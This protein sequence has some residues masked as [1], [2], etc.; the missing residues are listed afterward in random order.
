MVFNK[1]VLFIHLG[2]TG[3]MSVTD[4]LCNTLEPPV[5]HVVQASEFNTSFTIFNEIII[6]WKRHANLVETANFLKERAI[7]LSDF[8]VVFIIV[9]NPLDLDLSYYKHLN[10]PLFV[11]SLAGN[12]ANQKL[13]EIASGEYEKFAKETFVHY[14]G[15]LCDFFEIKGKMPENLQILRFEDLAEAVPKLV[16]PFAVKEML[17]PHHNKSVEIKNQSDKL[18]DEA[19]ISIRDKYH[20]IWKNFYPNL[21][22]PLKS[23][24][25]KVTT[26]GKQYLFIG[27]CAQS[28]ASVLSKIIGAHQQIIIGIERYNKLMN[29]NDFKLKDEH[30]VKE[31]FFNIKEGDTFYNDFFRFEPHRALHE[32]WESATFIGLKYSLLDKVFGKIKRTFGSVQYIY[33][34]RS[35]YNVAESNNH[36]KQ[37]S[38]NLQ[39]INNYLQAVVRWNESLQNVIEELD[40]GENIICIN[41][42][43]FLF[44]Q[45]TIE[46]VFNSLGLEMD[47]F[48]EN[49]LKKARRIAMKKKD[50]KRLLSFEEYDF[51]TRNAHFELYENLNTNYN[52]LA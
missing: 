27:G 29:K 40:K 26:D 13:L 39:T 11:K 5:Y 34:Y 46:K 17:F 8:K 48:T 47:F 7:E 23:S 30:F 3:G 2:K 33:I 1:D 12:P 20:Y 21:Q 50:Q 18:S 10:T 31:R 28:G 6:P 51:I 35:I 36:Q 9:R 42:E 24:I 43:N 15:S 4:Y 37:D 16:K 22:L 44:S 41:Y 49:E 25:R 32:K 45:K 19:L 38:K 14:N 52:T